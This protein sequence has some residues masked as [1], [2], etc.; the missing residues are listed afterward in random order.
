MWQE[1]QAAILCS[2]ALMTQ[3][4]AS[5]IHLVLIAYQRQDKLYLVLFK[6]LLFVS[7]ARSLTS[8]INSFSLEH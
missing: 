3:H 5:K 6:L 8:I 1:I 2:K 7:M 4:H